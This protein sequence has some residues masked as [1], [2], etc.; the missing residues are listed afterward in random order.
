VSARGS[1]PPSARHR[2][3]GA[4]V[5]RARA[6]FARDRDR[7][8]RHRSPRRRRGTHPREPP[9]RNRFIEL[10]RANLW[11]QPRHS[12]GALMRLLL[13]CAMQ[14][15]ACRRRARWWRCAF[16]G[17]RPATWPGRGLRHIG[18]ADGRSLFAER[19]ASSP[20]GQRKCLQLAALD[21]ARQQRVQRVSLNLGYGGKL[22]GGGARSFLRGSQD[23][24]AI[25]AARRTLTRL[26]RR[27][28]AMLRLYGRAGGRR[29]RSLALRVAKRLSGCGQALVLVNERTQ[30]RQARADLFTDAV[31]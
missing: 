17:P 10:F 21:Q 15:E 27:C 30:L 11:S 8:R 3:S 9:R 6:V 2:P 20:G 19:V 31:K 28:L 29:D 7:S 18:G 24:L 22:C 14:L 12:D 1:S 16:A 23:G 26:S 5:K 13:T 25:G 4:S